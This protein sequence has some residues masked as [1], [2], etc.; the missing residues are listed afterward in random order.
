MDRTGF[1][2]VGEDDQTGIGGSVLFDEFVIEFHEDVA[3]LDGLAVFYEDLEALAV[4][5]DRI[6]ADV[7]HIFYTVSRSHADGVL[8]VEDKACFTVGRSDDD[9]AGRIDEEAITRHFL[10]ERVVRCF[11]D[12]MGHAR[13]G[14]A[15]D[16][17]YAFGSLCLIFCCVSHFTGVDIFH[18]MIPPYNSAACRKAQRKRN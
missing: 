8:R 13:K 5:L 4:Q 12:G 7:K 15:E 2:Q 18:E 6:D 17:L 11:C 16:L 14:R 1:I 9:T 10:S 3:L